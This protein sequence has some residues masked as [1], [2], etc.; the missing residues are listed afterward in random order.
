MLCKRCQRPPKT[1]EGGYVSLGNISV[2]DKYIH[3]QFQRNPH[4]SQS[5]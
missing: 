3:P 5:S 4:A 1:P 2:A